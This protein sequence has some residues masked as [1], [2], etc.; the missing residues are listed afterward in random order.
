MLIHQMVHEIELRTDRVAARVQQH[1]AVSFNIATCAAGD[2]QYSIGAVVIEWPLNRDTAT[3][4]EY[5]PEALPFGLAC[6]NGA[7]T[8]SVVLPHL[9]LILSIEDGVVETQHVTQ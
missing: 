8:L 1:P 5:R 4:Q 2:G 7:G 9:L 6:C 3:F